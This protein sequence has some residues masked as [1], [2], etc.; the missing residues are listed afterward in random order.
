MRMRLSLRIPLGVTITVFMLGFVV[1]LREL[2]RGKPVSTTLVIIWAI[3]VVI[4][5][6]ITIFSGLRGRKK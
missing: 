3:A 6:A 1:F 2:T 5:A 4:L